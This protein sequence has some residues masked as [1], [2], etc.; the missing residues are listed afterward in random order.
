[1]TSFAKTIGLS[2]AVLGLVAAPAMAAR[3]KAPKTE[4]SKTHM[5]KHKTNDAKKN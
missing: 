2:V 4:T 3:T 1:M 5:H